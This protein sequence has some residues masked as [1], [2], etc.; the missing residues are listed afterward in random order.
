MK[1]LYINGLGGSQ[2]HIDRQISMLNE[3]G[4]I[5][6][7]NV[8]Y[9]HG[10]DHAYNSVTNLI[11]DKQIDL[12]IGIGLGAVIASHISANYGIKFV[13]LNPIIHPVDTMSHWDGAV[14]TQG[15]EEFMIDSTLSQ[16]YPNMS[17]ACDG[18]II[19]ETGD[20]IVDAYK[21]MDEME[22]H[23]TVEVIRGGSHSFTNISKAI[24]II[25]TY[26]KES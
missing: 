25:K 5:I 13:A 23:F 10:Y 1:I 3:L 15:N 7:A 19:A 12:I 2:K 4:E 16:T 6:Q 18:L 17:C 20:E 8:R 21:T 14:I 24:E 9:K 11:L 22:K 26:I